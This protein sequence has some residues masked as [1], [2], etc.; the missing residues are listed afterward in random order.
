[1]A[2]I[3]GYMLTWT[4]YGSWLPGDERGY[5]KDGEILPGDIKILKR[6]RKRQKQTTVK[7]DTKEKEIV[8][9]VIIDESI[10]IKQ[11]VEALVVYSNHVHLL[12]RPHSDS[13]EE[14]AGRYKSLTTRA[15]WKNGR[16]GRIWTKGFDKRY[17]FNEVELEQRKEYVQ[18]HKDD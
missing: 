10:R 3:V 18:K 13:I 5:V 12:A 9:Q 1:M 7:L 6:N 16:K 8:K 15:I 17:C 4:T 11:K 14:V 2:K